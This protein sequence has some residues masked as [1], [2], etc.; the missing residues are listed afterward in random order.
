MN[1]KSRILDSALTLFSEKGYH[2]VSVAEI[3]DAVGIKAPSLYK[4]YKSKRDIFNGILSEMQTRYEKQTATLQMNGSNAAVDA[5][6]FSS[7]SEDTLI[8]MGIGL[9]TYFLH[10][11]YVCRFRKMLTIE[12]FHNAELTTLYTKQYTDDPLSYQSRIFSMLGTCGLFRPANADVMA[13][14]FYAP[15][16]LLLTLCD[17]EPAREPE[18]LQLLEQ[19]I[20][21]FN[22]IY[23]KENAQ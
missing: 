5:D 2:S 8:Q 9:F 13:L 11:D 7:V 16:Y 6:I 1:T 21:Q 12:Q 18:A 10:D 17:R 15:L 4:H 20:R 23:K 14:H 3:A 22:Q 19:H